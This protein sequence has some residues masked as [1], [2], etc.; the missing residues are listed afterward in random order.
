MIMVLEISSL[1]CLVV[2]AFSPPVKEIDLWNNSAASLLT[3]CYNHLD[4][5]L[6]RTKFLASSHFLKKAWASRRGE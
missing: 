2:E 5:V 3:V 1:F 6:L 4:K